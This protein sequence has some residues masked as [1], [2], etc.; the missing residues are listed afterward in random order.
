MAPGGASADG[1]RRQS[2]K[3]K[4]PRGGIQKRGAIGKTDRDGDLIMDGGKDNS[5]PK[6]RSNA[7]KRTLKGGAKPRNSL[8]S[9]QTQQAIIKGLNSQQVNVVQPK[10]QRDVVQ[11]RVRG[12]EDSAAAKNKDGGLKDL[13]SFLERKASAMDGAPRRGV[14][15]KKV[16]WTRFRI[17]ACRKRTF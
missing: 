12:L 4:G 6:G 10:R 13:L 14:K 3:S 15:I 9:A 5:T 2:G 7:S 16:C 1:P 8:A 17:H 11:I